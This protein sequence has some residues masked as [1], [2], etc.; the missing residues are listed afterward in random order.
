MNLPVSVGSRC[1]IHVSR[2]VSGPSGSEHL[3]SSGRA[4][5]CL[6]RRCV[7]PG[8]HFAV[9]QEHDPYDKST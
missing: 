7:A 8:V 9:S 1:S 5:S 3:T 4:I 2:H 6:K